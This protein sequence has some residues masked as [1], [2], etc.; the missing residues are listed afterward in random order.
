MF[1]SAISNAFSI[2][3]VTSGTALKGGS[4]VDALRASRPHKVGKEYTDG[5]FTITKNLWALGNYSLFV[6]PGMTRLN[7]SRSDGRNAVEAAQDVMVAAFSGGADKLVMVLVN[8]TDYP[9]KIRPELKNFK[10]IKSYRTYMTS[11]DVN[12]NLKPSKDQRF[13]GTFSLLP[14]AVTTVVLN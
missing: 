6:R 14:R 3:A 9:R 11:A 1:S 7:T 2:R 12:N 4:Q 8:Y 5:E 10:G 13:N